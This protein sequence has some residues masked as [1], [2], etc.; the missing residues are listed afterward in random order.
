MNK[1]RLLNIIEDMSES[2]KNIQDCKEVLKSTPEN[3]T[4]IFIEFGLKQIFADFFI[5]VE[6]LTSMT[7]K[8]LGEFKIGIDMKN[9]L[10]IL[11]NNNIIDSDIYYFLNQ[12]RLLRNR[13]FH[14]YKQPSR[15]ELL[16]FI[17]SN[18]DKFNSVLELA[19]KYIKD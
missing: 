6:N 5:T 16:E 4:T 18:I 14:R 8:E 10:L 15:E 9:S 2:I 11:N 17:D 1:E 3:K 12:A 13:I 19:K 7:L